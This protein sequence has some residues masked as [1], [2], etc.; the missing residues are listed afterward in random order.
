MNNFDLTGFRILFEWSE[1]WPGRPALVLFFAEYL[2]YLLVIGFFFILFEERGRRRFFWFLEAA[3]ALLVS[4]GLLV[5]LIHYFYARPRP[6]HFLE[7]TAFVSEPTMNSMPSGHATF[8]FALALVVFFMSRQ[9]G[10]VY[11][12]LATA[13][14]LGRIFAGVHWPSDILAGAA[15]G[16]LSAFL[17][18]L[19]LLPSLKSLTREAVH[20]EHPLPPPTPGQ[21]ALGI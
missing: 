9:W 18:H 10:V 14:G 16:V 7:F 3:L 12:L 15:L 6:F 13:V 17:V 20:D 8:F 4:R 11:F 19:L 1:R 2:P 5:E 21:E